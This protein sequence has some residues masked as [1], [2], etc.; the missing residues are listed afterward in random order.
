[1]S[2]SSERRPPGRRIHK[3]A[4]LTLRPDASARHRD[5]TTATRG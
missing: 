5:T 4:V 2:I 1:L 3:T